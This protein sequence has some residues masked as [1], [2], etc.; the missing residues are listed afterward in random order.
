[1]NCSM[2]NS[3]DLFE[4]YTYCLFYGDGTATGKRTRYSKRI[5]R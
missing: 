2:N 4:N 3:Y 5:C 1:M